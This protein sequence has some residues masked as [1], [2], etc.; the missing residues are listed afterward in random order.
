MIRS[1]T[2]DQNE[3]GIHTSC[4]E[5]PEAEIDLRSIGPNS[6][7]GRYWSKNKIHGNCYLYDGG[8]EVIIE[9]V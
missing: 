2:I 7:I 3:P 8:G 5:G 9:Q 4:I 1:I 6:T